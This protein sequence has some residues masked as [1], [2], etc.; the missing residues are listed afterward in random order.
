M[1]DNLY[2][3]KFSVSPR[4]IVGDRFETRPSLDGV[5][6]VETGLL[7]IAKLGQADRLLQRRKIGTVGIARVNV[8]L[9]VLENLQDNIAWARKL[10]ERD[11]RSEPDRVASVCHALGQSVEVSVKEFERL[12]YRNRAG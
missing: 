6:N 1:P 2:V 5:S 12:P 8:G 7:M 9:Q 3:E 11:P 4:Q 10:A